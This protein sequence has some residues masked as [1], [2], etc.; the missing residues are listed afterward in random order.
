MIIAMVIFGASI[1]STISAITIDAGCNAKIQQFRDCNQKIR[2]QRESEQK[3]KEDAM[4]A[5]FTSN[6]CTA[7]GQ[8]G[9]MDPKKEQCFKDVEANLKTK[10]ETC[11]QGKIQ[12]LVFPQD[13]KPQGEHRGGGGARGGHGDQ[14]LQQACSNNA[15]N[16]AKVKACI[17]AA[18]GPQSTPDQDKTRFDSN[19]KSR[20][21]C[22]AILDAKCKS[23]LD[24]AKQAVCEC[25]QQIHADASARAA[26]FTS[27]PSCQGMSAPK[28]RQGGPQQQK[29]C[30]ESGK[31]DYCK[32]GF[33][34]WQADKKSKQ[35]GGH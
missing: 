33:D 1:L 28:P 14:G 4:K 21:Q 20:G 10:V 30:D 6:G 16:V 5:C 2:D 11:V 35:G 32:L 7:P 18:R 13:S 17:Q 3:T 9:Q 15:G 23:S 24:A 12:G 26:V 31:K 34:A 25:G 19:C 29:S 27:T 8:G 22:D